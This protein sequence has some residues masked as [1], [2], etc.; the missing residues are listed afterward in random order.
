MAMRQTVTGWGELDRSQSLKDVRRARGRFEDALRV[1]PASVI[2]SNGLAASYAMELR[3]PHGALT[4]EQLARYAKVVEHTRQIAPDD[5]TALLIW[6]SM[7]IHGGRPDLAIPAIERSIGIV[8]SYPNAYVLLAQAKLRSGR[9]GEVQEL[10]DKAIERGAGDPKRTSS[11]YLLAAEA[12]LLLG[13]DEK[14]A[15]LAKRSIAEWPSNVDAHA[16]LAA[17]DALAGRDA[18]AA[19]EMAEVRRRNPD[20]TLLTFAAQH[21]SNDPVYLTQRTRLFDGL[22]RAGLPSG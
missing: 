9:A 16:V 19:N 21:R 2:A 13:E 18:E 12:A 4:T 15:S 1:D 11:A 22:R 6:G 3:D 5:A 8:P 20:A 14:A 17:I 7:E 10:A